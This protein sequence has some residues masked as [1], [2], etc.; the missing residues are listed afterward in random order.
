MSQDTSGRVFVPDFNATDTIMAGFRHMGQRAVP[1]LR[2]YL[3][4]LIGVIVITVF[5]DLMAM[6]AKR[7]AVFGQLSGRGVG[8]G[9]T[10]TML[11]IS[12]LQGAVG[13]VFGSII[14][15]EEY[16]SAVGLKSRGY[17]F[18]LGTAEPPIF[19]VSEETVTLIMSGLRKLPAMWPAL[20]IL[21]ISMA[22]G[23]FMA[24]TMG[25]SLSGGGSGGA[26][27]M[28]LICRILFAFVSLWVFQRFA[29]YYLFRVPVIAHTGAADENAISQTFTGAFPQSLRT[30][31]F[32][33]CIAAFGASMLIGIVTGWL[34]EAILKGLDIFENGGVGFTI[35]SI[36][37]IVTTVLSSMFFAGWLAEVWKPEGA[38]APT[39][40]ATEPDTP[41]AAAPSDAPASSP[42]TDET[43]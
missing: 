23:V 20:I 24:Q 27:F 43:S 26:G 40:P 6:D 29:R 41:A 9:D 34:T 3:V 42:D 39:T 21:P 8:F 2:Q 31:M 32:W 10:V 14:A 15:M 22:M 38:A 17:R 37:G 12:L 5:L 13:V 35:Q 28:L 25:S 30:A 16:Q 33:K 1:G 7:A 11:F 36:F 18:K 19:A 4:M